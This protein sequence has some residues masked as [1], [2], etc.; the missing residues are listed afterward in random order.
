[1][2]KAPLIFAD[3]YAEYFSELTAAHAELLTALWLTG[4][5]LVGDPMP[6]FPATFVIREVY[7][8]AGSTV[9]KTTETA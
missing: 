8:Y 5:P 1:M 3:A 4:H 9:K 7:A 6:H 2:S